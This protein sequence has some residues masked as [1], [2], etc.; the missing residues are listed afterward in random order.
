MIGQFSVDK[1]IKFYQMM[2][3]SSM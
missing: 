2:Q 3:I 1:I